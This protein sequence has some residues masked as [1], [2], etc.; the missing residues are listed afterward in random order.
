[1]HDLAINENLVG[2]DTVADLIRR[3]GGSGDLDL[4]PLAV[5]G[6]KF[7]LGCEVLELFVN[8]LF[9]DTT[10]SLDEW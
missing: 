9:L 1:M 2:T 10:F 4:A 5:S 3:I 7:P 8:T 6:N